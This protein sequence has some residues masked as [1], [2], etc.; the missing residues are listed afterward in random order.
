[1]FIFLMVLTFWFTC[2]FISG[3]LM[4]AFWQRNWPIIAA[5]G[6]YIDRRD[7]FICILGG[8]L[9]LLATLIFLTGKEKHGFLIPFTKADCVGYPEQPNG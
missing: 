6:R 5:D 8:T 7:F 4:Y 1:M 9:F 2:G 3:G